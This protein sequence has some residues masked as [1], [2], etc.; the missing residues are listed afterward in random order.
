MLKN[1][2]LVTLAVMA[3]FLILF[4][5]GNS[6]AS[7]QDDAIILMSEGKWKEAIKIYDIILS[8]GN[9]N[10][11]ALLNRSKARKEIKDVEGSAEDAK[12]VVSLVKKELK[13]R[14]DDYGLYFFAGQAHG[15]LENYNL[16]IEHIEKSKE[17]NPKAPVMA[18]LKRLKMERAKTK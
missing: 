18:I 13:N 11:P 16:A 15:L 8:T 4:L 5:S 1:K 7:S 14:P 10:I 12:R 9:G 6:C 2:I 17:L 3:N